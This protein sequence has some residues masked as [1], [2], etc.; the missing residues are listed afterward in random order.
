MPCLS[1]A[2]SMGQCA[3]LPGSPT[4]ITLEASRMAGMLLDVLTNGGNAV[5]TTAV[6]VSS[7]PSDGLSCASSAAF[8]RTHRR[9]P[10]ATT[11]DV[12]SGAERTDARMGAACAA[13]KRNPSDGKLAARKV[14]VARIFRLSSVGW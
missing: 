2:Y 6:P 7:A 10:R 9:P 11:L 14:T 13:T 4:L 1:P 12:R 3:H 5:T 8:A